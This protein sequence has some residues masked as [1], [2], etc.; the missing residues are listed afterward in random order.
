[1]DENFGTEFWNEHVTIQRI[2]N[3]PYT[4]EHPLLTMPKR[5]KQRE[6]EGEVTNAGVSVRV[7]EAKGVNWG[8]WQRLGFQGGLDLLVAAQYHEDLLARVVVPVQSER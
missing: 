2:P 5:Q 4:T 8:R 7:K 3:K 1:M 6:R